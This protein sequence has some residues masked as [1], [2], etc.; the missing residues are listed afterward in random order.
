MK[1]NKRIFIMPTTDFFIK[2][3]FKSE[4]NKRFLISFLNSFFVKAHRRNC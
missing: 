1:V 2:K 3:I 4:K